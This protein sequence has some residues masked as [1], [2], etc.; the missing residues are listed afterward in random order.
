MLVPPQLCSANHG[1]SQLGVLASVTVGL[2][3]AG[4]CTSAGKTATQRLHAP[5]RRR[6]SRGIA[7]DLAGS[8][9]RRLARSAPGWRNCKGEL[10]RPLHQ[11]RAMCRCCMREFSRRCCMG[12]PWS[13]P[14]G[15]ASSCT[16]AEQRYMFGI[17]LVYLMNDFWAK[18]ANNQI[19]CGRCFPHKIGILEK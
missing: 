11:R 13:T 8:E 4:P 16:S 5:H 6:R 15:R 18:T 1:P 19:S 2:E 3:H 10:R 14:E 12:D 9:M 7:W 17:S